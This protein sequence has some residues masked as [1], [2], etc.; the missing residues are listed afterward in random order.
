MER[1]LV[2]KALAPFVSSSLSGFAGGTSPDVAKT[3]RFQ[4]FAV[5]ETSSLFPEHHFLHF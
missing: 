2:D 5:D 3:P 1:P 4:E